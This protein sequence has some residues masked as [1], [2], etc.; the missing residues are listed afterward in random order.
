MRALAGLIPVLL[1]LPTSAQS[2]DPPVAVDVNPDPGIVEIYLEAA[3]VQWE[4]FPV[5]M[6]GLMTT[7]WAYGFDP[8]GP[9]RLPVSYS[10][11]GPTIE[12]DVGQLLRVHF[13]NHLGEPTTVHWHGVELPAEMDGSN[14]SQAWIQDGETFTYEFPLLDAS[15]FWY[16]PH[17]RTFDQVEKGLHGCLLVRDPVAESALGLWDPTGTSIEEHIVVF[18]DVLLDTGLQVVPAFSYTDPLQN[19]VYQVNGREGNYKLINGRVSTDVALTVQNARPQRWRVVNAANT[20]FCRM[21][22]RNTNGGLDPLM[23]VYQV[24]TDGG[25]QARRSERTNVTYPDGDHPGFYPQSYEGIF[26]TPGERL[27]IVFVP[28]GSN[29]QTFT[30]YWAD[31]PRGRHAAVYDSTGAIKLIDDPLDG[32]Y[33]KV[34]L[35]A[36]TLTG[37]DPG[38]PYFTPPVGLSGITE[39]S[40]TPLGN[41]P[42]TFGHGN[43]D[44]AGNIM[45][46]AQAQMVM[47]PGQGM[48]MVPLPTPLIDSFNAHDVNMGDLW[49][50]EITNLSHGDHPFHAHGFFF[51][52]QEVEFIDEDEPLNNATVQLNKTITRKD[53][54]RAPARPGAK[55]KSRSILRALVQFDDT[56]R[57]NRAF[58]SGQRPTFH[59]DGSWTSGGWLFHCHILEHSGRGMLSWYEVHDPADPFTLLGKQMEG[60][61]DKYPSLTAQGDLSNGSAVTLKLID[62]APKTMA[63][64]V[65]GDRASRRSF[66]GGELVPGWGPGEIN[67]IV[68]PYFLG[69]KK[70]L[71]SASGRV[72]WD[73][74]QWSAFPSGTT[75]YVQVAVRD[76]GGPNG[77]SLSNALMFT[78]P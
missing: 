70:A 55:G 62:A 21:D 30:V 1:A 14:I 32:K 3:E 39:P 65:I 41:L 66:A 40:G 22:L 72:T 18:D 45:L 67:A 27:D 25:L 47:I 59:P 76:P 68:K 42:V 4:Y 13:T 54:I 34:P 73:V 9:G 23:P 33:P 50:W 52:P 78:R 74:K 64:L 31:W 75:F 12:V 2:F 46:F 20:T 10:V 53:T 19:A 63:Y 5:S 77:W 58:A 26:V 57:K 6:P 8:D 48:T 43:P 15:L 29:G 38:P 61:G 44:A 36:L 7:V 60:S 69:T 37:V 51:Y 11:P 49:Q 16:H 71:T 17:V 35:I 24:G 28:A 56:G